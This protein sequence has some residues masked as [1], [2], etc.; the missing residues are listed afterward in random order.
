MRSERQYLTDIVEAADAIAR[1]VAN[2]DREEFLHDELRQSAVMQKIELGKR[3]GKYRRNFGSGILKSS[4]RLLWGC[5]ISWCI[6]T[7]R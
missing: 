6:H 2:I 7:S 5:E 3:P 4:G 1:F